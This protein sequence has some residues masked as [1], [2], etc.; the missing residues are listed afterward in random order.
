MVRQQTAVRT[1]RLSCRKPNLQ[2][3]PAELG[4]IVCRSAFVPSSP[5][6]CFF[7]CDYSQNE[8]RIL[9]HMSKDGAL[10]TLFQDKNEADIYKQMSSVITGKKLSEVTSKERSISKQ[11]TLAILYGMGLA[12][13]SKKLEVDKSRAQTFFNSFFAR[14]RGVQRWINETKQFAKKNGY[15]CTI[16]GRRR[17][18]EDISSFDNAKKAQAERQAVNSVIQGSA[19]DLMKMAMIKVRIIIK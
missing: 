16:S 6:M 14:F 12:Q 17:Y 15:V 3:V 18:L 1:G 10:I 2:Q 4:N 8:V 9:A 13:V 7:A 19:A 5:D 11:V